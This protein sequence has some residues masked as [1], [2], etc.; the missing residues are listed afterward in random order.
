MLKNFLAEEKPDEDYKCDKCKSKGTCKK[1]LLLYKLP[2]ILVITLK[3]FENRIIKT[4]Y[5]IFA[6]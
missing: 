3:R 4:K 6:S 2:K 1:K 5:G